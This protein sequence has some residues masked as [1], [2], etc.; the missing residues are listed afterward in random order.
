MST[1]LREKAGDAGRGGMDAAGTQG[2]AATRP[3]V[4]DA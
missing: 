1:V 2:L 3:C 4:H